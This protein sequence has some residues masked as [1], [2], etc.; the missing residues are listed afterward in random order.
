VKALD[1]S[2]PRDKDF[3]K[4][5]PEVI[6]EPETRFIGLKQY[7]AAMIVFCIAPRGSPECTFLPNEEVAFLKAVPEKDGDP[8]EFMSL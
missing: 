1:A 4:V 2:F 3:R 6:A 8:G 5:K 7:L